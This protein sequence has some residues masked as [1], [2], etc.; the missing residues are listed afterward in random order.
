M[1]K[2]QLNVRIPDLTRDQ[3]DAL[4]AKYKMTP[5]ELVTLAVDRIYQKEQAHEGKPEMAER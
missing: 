4:C 2:Q 3:I 5:G 1:T